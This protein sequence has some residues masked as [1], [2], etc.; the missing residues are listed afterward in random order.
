MIMLYGRTIKL[1]FIGN[2]ISCIINKSKYIL[3]KHV[4]LSLYVKTT[5]SSLFID[6]NVQ[7]VHI[8]SY[9]S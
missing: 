1:K 9:Q 6:R 7:L 5:I 8:A 2:K 3:V 4:P